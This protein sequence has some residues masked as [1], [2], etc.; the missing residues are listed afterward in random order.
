MFSRGD[1][2][3]VAEIKRPLWSATLYDLLSV[4]AS[5]R[6]RQVLGRVHVEKRSVWSLTEARAALERLIGQAVD[7]SS[8]DEFLRAYLVEP[9]MIPTVLASSFAATLEM[10][11]EGEIELHQQGAFAPIYLRQRRAKPEAVPPG[12]A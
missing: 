7:W 8:L 11:R 3:P 5:Q 9:S 1:P 6:Q 4:Y 12:A 2:E 10:A